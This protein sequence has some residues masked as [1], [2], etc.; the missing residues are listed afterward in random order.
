VY[1]LPKDYGFGFRNAEDTIWGIFRAD[2]LSAKVWG[3]VNLLESRY[4]SGFNIIYDD[5]LDYVKI[6]QTYKHVYFWNQTLT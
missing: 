4:G 6:N 5:G 1:V 3:D 2:D